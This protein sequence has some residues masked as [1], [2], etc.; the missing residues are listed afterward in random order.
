[1]VQS[2]VQLDGSVE[3]ASRTASG[4]ARVAYCI[5][6]SCLLGPWLPVQ[7]IGTSCIPL[8][9]VVAAS[10]PVFRRPGGALSLSLS[11]GTRLMILPRICR[12][13]GN[14]ANMAARRARETGYLASIQL[15]TPIGS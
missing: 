13:Q 11:M 1:M 9:A 3:P 15:G 6:R 4:Q 14:L 5:A 7:Q 12:L 2:T 8:A 10:A